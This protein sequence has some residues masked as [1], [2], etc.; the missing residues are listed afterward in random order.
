M[1]VSKTHDDIVGIEHWPETVIG[2]GTDLTPV[3]YAKSCN[4]QG[5]GT[6]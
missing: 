5:N 2:E 6:T 1:I 4:V 3:K